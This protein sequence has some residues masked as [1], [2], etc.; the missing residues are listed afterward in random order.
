MNQEQTIPIFDRFVSVFNNV[1]DT[2][3]KE[4]KLKEFLAL[5]LEYR[6]QITRI[7][8]ATD[9]NVR[10][11][12][13]KQL[14]M[15]TTSGIFRG[16]RKAECLFAHSG[17]IC[18]DIDEKDNT[19]V[20][21][22]EHLKEKVLCRIEEVAY[23]A[24]SVGGKGFFV[25]VPL[26]Y[27]LQH[28]RQFKKLQEQFA[29]MGITIDS[30]CSDVNRLRCVSFDDKPY[31]NE[32][33]K[34]YDGLYYESTLSRSQYIPHRD[35]T[36]NSDEKALLACGYAVRHHIDM[37]MNYL[38]WMKIG[39]ALASLGEFGREL[40]HMVSSVSEK[41]NAHETDKKFTEL[42]RSGNR[43]GIGTFFHYCQQYGVLCD[44]TR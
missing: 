3:P 32:K 9:K 38:D 16:G 34:P 4:M 37:T 35:F 14:P 13:K 29:E 40:F 22:F 21:E 6:E 27:P 30:A 19:Q 31:I 8:V 24:Q 42:L 1:R 43:I 11:S 2:E 18:I 10:N 5:G 26:K 33:A 28:K 23:A 25:I 20:P 12:L 7:R 44:G 15:M 39:F 17:L 36:D 41:Y